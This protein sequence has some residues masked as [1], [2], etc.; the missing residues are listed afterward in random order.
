MYSATGEQHYLDKALL[1]TEWHYSHRNKESGLI[2]ESA[3]ASTEKH[4]YWNGWHMFTEVVGCYGS[5]LLRSY[6]YSGNTIF[7]DRAIGYLKAYDKYGWNKE[8]RNYYGMIRVKDNKP[9]VEFNAAEGAHES[10]YTP[11]GYVNVWRTIMYTWEFTIIS[12]QAAVY[13]YEVSDIGGG[14][15]DPELLTI[16]EH[17]TEVI[18][19]EL[20]PRVG[21]RFKK[22]LEAAMPQ[23]KKTGGTYAENYGRAISFFVHMYRATGKDKYL[24]YATDLANEA[25]EKLYANGLF[26]GHPAKP[27]YQSNDGVGLLLYALL[28]LD[29]PNQNLGGAF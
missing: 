21:K 27:Y 15:K 4:V 26:K 10:P 29:K 28:E 19:R 5:Q 18:E 20:P 2:P 12:A 8:D 13:A 24:K 22:E 23:V 3:W 14:K 7:R 25:V 1:L 11:I 6:E 17:W 16:A 9:I